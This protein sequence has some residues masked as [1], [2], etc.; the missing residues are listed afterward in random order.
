M[1]MLC[2]P[3]LCFVVG[4]S[5]PLEYFLI[6]VPQTLTIQF[7]TC[8]PT[9]TGKNIYPLGRAVLERQKQG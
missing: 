9:N 1:C 4:Y 8:M 7:G 5:L 6:L 2:L 3:N